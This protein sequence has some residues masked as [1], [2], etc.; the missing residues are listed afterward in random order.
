MLP[1]VCDELGIFRCGKDIAFVDI[2]LGNSASLEILIINNTAIII[3]TI[4]IITIT[5]ITI[6]ITTIIIITTTIIITII[7]TI[8]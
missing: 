4:I 8:L 3:I 1:K 7:T 6:I 5:I 2:S